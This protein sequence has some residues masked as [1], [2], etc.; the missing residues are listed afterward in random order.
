MDD[1]FNELFY[2]DDDI[3]ALALEMLVLLCSLQM[4]ICPRRLQLNNRMLKMINNRMPNNHRLN[5]RML[6]MLNNHRFNN[7]TLINYKLSNSI[8]DN[9]KFNIRRNNSP[10]FVP[11]V[12]VAKLGMLLRNERV[13]AERQRTKKQPHLL[14]LQNHWLQV[15]SPKLHRQDHLNA[16]PHHSLMH[17]R[18]LLSI[19][20][21]PLQYSL[22]PL[23]MD[24]PSI[25]RSSPAGMKGFPG[26]LAKLI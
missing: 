7:R 11:A 25:Y 21:P 22:R 9:R 15:V 4:V 16:Q 14:P 2:G 13:P 8:L 5:N 18:W 3:V 26:S 1:I 19:Q 12:P 10:K 20:L 17:P 6:K 24:S 23:R